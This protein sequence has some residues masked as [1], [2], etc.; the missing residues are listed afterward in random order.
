MTGCHYSSEVE[1]EVYYSNTWLEV[2]HVIS[3]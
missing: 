3:T 1:V 2:E